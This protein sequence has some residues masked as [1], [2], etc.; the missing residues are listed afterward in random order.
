MTDTEERPL[1]SAVTI[2]KTETV[3]MVFAQL[4]YL[5][6]AWFNSY[7]SCNFALLPVLDFWKAQVTDPRWQ[8]DRCLLGFII[9]SKLNQ[10]SLFSHANLPSGWATLWMLWRVIQAKHIVQWRMLEEKE[11]TI[12]VCVLKEKVGTDA[13][14]DCSP[15][16]KCSQ[17]CQNVFKTTESSMDLC[18]SVNSM[19]DS[20]MKTLPFFFPFLL[21]RH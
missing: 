3:C 15:L 20:K 2:L 21:M 12:N 11:D 9:I 18:H 7:S 6:R 1:T 5:L 16:V 17:H 14:W 10:W 13:T 4:C 19:L 8:Q